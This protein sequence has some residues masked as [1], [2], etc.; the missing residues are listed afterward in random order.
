MFNI[1]TTLYK[2]PRRIRK[3][4]DFD[5]ICIEIRVKSRFLYVFVCIAFKFC[6]ILS[7]RRNLKWCLVKE[8]CT[9]KTHTGKYFKMKEYMLDLYFQHVVRSNFSKNGLFF[10][11]THLELP[12]GQIGIPAFFV[13]KIRCKTALSGIK[14]LYPNCR[15]HDRFKLLYQGRKKSVAVDEQ[16]MPLM[17]CLSF[18]NTYVDKTYQ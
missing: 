11:V 18:N 6:P 16:T 13:R 17:N 14:R 9:Q 15:I 1:L 3:I 8:F 12:L 4:I 10:S 2:T 7:Q 5:A